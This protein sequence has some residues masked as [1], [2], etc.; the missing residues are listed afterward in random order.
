MIDCIKQIYVPV[1]AEE[2]ERKTQ[3][4]FIFV[5]GNCAFRTQRVVVLKTGGQFPISLSAFG[6]LYLLGAE[7][8]LSVVFGVVF[9]TIA[10]FAIYHWF[11]VDLLYL[12]YIAGLVA[13]W[14]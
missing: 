7:Q 12:V 14:S 2:T 4:T 6:L 9:L 1:H 10:C 5:R 11:A 13:G 8:W 3:R